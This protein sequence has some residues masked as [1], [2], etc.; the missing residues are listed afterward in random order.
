VG[1]NTKGSPPLTPPERG[2]GKMKNIYN[3][4]ENSL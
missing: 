1:L 3:M 4:E 2:I